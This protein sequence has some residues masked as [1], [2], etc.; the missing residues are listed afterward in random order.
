MP[1]SFRIRHFRVCRFNL[2]CHR[3]RPFCAVDTTAN[4]SHPLWYALLRMRRFHTQG[5]SFC[6][7][8][9]AVCAWIPQRSICGYTRGISCGSPPC[10]FVVIGNVLRASRDVIGMDWLPLSVRVVYIAHGF[11]GCPPVYGRVIVRPRALI[12]R[13]CSRPLTSPAQRLVLVFVMVSIHRQS[14]PRPSP[15]NSGICQ[16]F[17]D[18]LRISLSH[19]LNVF[20]FFTVLVKPNDDFTFGWRDSSR[21]AHQNIT[22]FAMYFACVLP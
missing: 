5:K 8:S 21:C 9:R 20:D 14:Q 3:N 17:V 15:R 6:G 11:F 10:V 13:F 7:K 2:F 1:D 4:T 22:P 19:R 18:C 16:D 12:T